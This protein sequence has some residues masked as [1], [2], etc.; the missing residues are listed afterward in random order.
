MRRTRPTHVKYTSAD[1]PRT[2][3]DRSLNEIVDV[4][5]RRRYGP[6]PP[7]RP[8]TI[9]SAP[10]LSVAAPAHSAAPP[11]LDPLVD[12]AVAD[13][14]EDGRIPGVSVTVV[15]DGRTVLAKGYGV[16]VRTQTPVD[17][18]AHASSAHSPSSSR[19]QAA[20]QLGAK[21][22]VDPISSGQ[23]TKIN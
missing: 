13:H 9:T 16:A 20:S 3:A 18:H 6:R 1:V 4:C 8:H 17:P 7:R 2:A 5:V 10:L 12:A 15:V 23:H 11:R 14:L 22:V 19:A 21:R